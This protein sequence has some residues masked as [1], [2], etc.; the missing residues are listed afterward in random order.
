MPIFTRR[1][2]QAM[3]DDLG[4]R[5][6]TPK[7]ADLHPR[8]EHVD[9]Q[10]ALAAEMVRLLLDRTCSIIGSATHASKSF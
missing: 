7:A 8:L 5:L 4:P 3:L 2:L 9:T 6:T 10:A 1:R